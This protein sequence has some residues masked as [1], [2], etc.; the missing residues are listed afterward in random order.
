[1]MWMSMRTIIP[2]V[3]EGHFLWHNP[4]IKRVDGNE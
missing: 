1:V 4:V 2:Q 3:D